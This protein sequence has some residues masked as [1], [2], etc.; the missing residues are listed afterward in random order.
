[1]QQLPKDEQECNMTRQEVW[2]HNFSNFKYGSMR[3]SAVQLKFATHLIEQLRQD[4]DLLEEE[5]RMDKEFIKDLMRS[6]D[7]LKSQIQKQD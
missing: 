4:V 5:R 3:G 1:M 7:E 2:D 6:I